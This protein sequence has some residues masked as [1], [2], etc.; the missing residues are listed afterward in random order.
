LEESKEM[1]MGQNRRKMS[2]ASQKIRTSDMKVHEGWLL[3]RGE[4]IKNWRQRY[5]VRAFHIH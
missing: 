4:H 1:M 3:K 5:F 2:T